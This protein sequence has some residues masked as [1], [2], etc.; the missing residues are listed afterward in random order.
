M[1]SS[2]AVLEGLGQLP[3]EV[4]RA[5]GQPAR[6]PGPGRLGLLLGRLRG[7]GQDQVPHR[8][9][10][11]LAG[12]ALEQ[13]QVGAAGAAPEPAEVG[14]AAGEQEHRHGPGAGIVLEQA[15]QLEPVHQR[16]VAVGD[17]QARAVLA[18]AHQGL[19]AVAGGAHRVPVPLEQGPVVEQLGR[20]V[21][22][23]QDLGGGPSVFGWCR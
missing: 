22:H 14:E 16:H 11:R 15:A 10:E 9:E 13:E 17:D 2:R 4:L 18:E 5:D 21:V 23:Q 3:A 12:A 19:G 20:A 7:R 1:V 6:R 8:R